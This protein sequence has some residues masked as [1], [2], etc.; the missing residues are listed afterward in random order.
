MN[1]VSSMIAQAEYMKY[2]RRQHARLRLEY[3][4]L[5]VSEMPSSCE[6]LKIPRVKLTGGA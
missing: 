6:V 1:A 3:L 4:R 2:Q 5:K